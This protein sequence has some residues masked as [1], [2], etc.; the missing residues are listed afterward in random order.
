MLLAIGSWLLVIFIV[1]LPIGVYFLQHPQDFM[2]R[3]TGV[4]VFAADNPIRAFGESLISYLGMFNFFGDPNWRHNFANAPM[5]PW[6][7]GI[8]FLIGIFFSVKEMFL[9]EP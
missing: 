4:S 3:M 9:N 7:L 5:L 1:G 6:P 2:S 8:L